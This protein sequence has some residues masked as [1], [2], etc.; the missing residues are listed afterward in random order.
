[1]A[2]HSRNQ[3]IAIYGFG[4]TTGS[5]RALE[6]AG[7]MART[8]ASLTASQPEK[9]EGRKQLWVVDES[10]LLST[11]Q[12]NAV[13]QKAQEAAV[14]RV[15]FVGDQRQHGAVE[16][17]KP[18]AQMQH[19]GMAMTSLNTIRRQKDLEVRYA[20]DLASKGATGAAVRQ[21]KIQGRVTEVTDEQQRYAAIAKRYAEEIQAGQHVLVVSPANAERHALNAAIRAELQARGHVAKEEVTQ[22]VFVN[23]GLTRAQKEHAGNYQA[24][25]V[26]Y[27][28]RG[29]KAHGI[30]AR[31]YVY[32]ESSHHERNQVTVRTEDGR[33]ATY[34]P[35]RLR[36]VE[37]FKEE[38][39]E[40]AQGDR[41]QFKAIDRDRKIANGA[42]GTIAQLAPDGRAHIKMDDGQ[43]FSAAIRTLRHIEYGYATTSHSSQGATVDTVLVNVNTQRS[44]HL[45][46]QKQ[47]YVSISRARY[48][49]QIYTNDTKALDQAV[50][51]DRQKSSALEAVR[52]TTPHV[53][54]QERSHG[55]Q[56]HQENSRGRA[57]RGITMG[58]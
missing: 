4:P 54:H 39:R 9:S 45:V 18:I 15:V 22:Q 30:A 12:V 35:S 3:Q 33:Q 1:L 38:Q 10:S 14:S 5:V 41:I 25:D 2:S 40:F 56:A 24:S 36:G 11:R 49:A 26:V 19:A 47:F 29:S 53:S 46:N 31:S 48:D 7:V 37:V 42:L 27:Y 8:V 32:V 28:S 17:G 43:E 6:E 34:S 13:L 20:V 21:L 52:D 55:Q 44:A 16:A 50:S 58:R 23:R 51:R 57:A